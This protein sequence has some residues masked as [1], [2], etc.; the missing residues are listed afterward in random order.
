MSATVWTTIAVLCAGTV[1]IKALGPATVGG[2][3]PSERVSSVIRLVAPALLAALVTYETF[4]PTGGHGVT[5]DARVVGVGPAGVALLLKLP[6]IVV[7]LAAAA[8]TA[9]VR[10]VT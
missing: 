5:V 6:L 1:A 10:A 9:L 2:R 8:T 4:N 7:V 3:E